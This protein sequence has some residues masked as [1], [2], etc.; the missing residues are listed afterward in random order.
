MLELVLYIVYVK[1]INSVHQL[2][3]R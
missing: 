1:N 2:R 3:K